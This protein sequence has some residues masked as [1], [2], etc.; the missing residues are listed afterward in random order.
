[1]VPPPL[2][3]FPVPRMGLGSGALLPMEPL[4]LCIFKRR[5]G[6]RD[7]MMVDVEGAVTLQQHALPLVY[8]AALLTQSSLLSRHS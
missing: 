3:E 4:V 2:K 1:M 5:E 8:I 7:A 6:A